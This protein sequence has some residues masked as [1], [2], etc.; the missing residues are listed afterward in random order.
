MVILILRFPKSEV[1]IKMAVIYVI[2]VIL[3]WGDETIQR[4]ESW[5]YIL[6]TVFSTAVQVQIIWIKVKK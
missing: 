3:C 2:I 4:E 1:N 5:P 6:A